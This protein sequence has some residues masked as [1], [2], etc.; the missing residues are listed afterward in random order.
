MSELV[1]TEI[2]RPQAQADV[3]DEDERFLSWDTLI[4]RF[5]AEPTYWLCTAGPEPHAMPVRGVWQNNRFQFS[6]SPQSRKAKNLRRQPEAVVH[7]ADTDAVLAIHCLAHE[8]T[9]HAA[10]QRFC[11]EYNPKYRGELTTDDVAQGAFAL[12]PHT[13]Y[14][15]SKGSGPGFRE[16]ATR[17]RFK[18][19]G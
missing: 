14:A 7:L 6:T 15:W 10:L 5:A 4:W 13:A 19:N 17:W 1:I 2:T 3:T 16:A 12:V 18:V 9:T 8:M 11:D